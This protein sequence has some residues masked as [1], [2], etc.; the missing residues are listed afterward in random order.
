MLVEAALSARQKIRW[1]V[2]W[3]HEATFTILDCAINIIQK[4]KQTL[5]LSMQSG[6]WLGSKDWRNSL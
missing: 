4:A 2:K 3:M 1:Y 5:T 6:G